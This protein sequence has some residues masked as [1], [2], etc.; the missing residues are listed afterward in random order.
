MTASFV[1]V[2]AFS[3]YQRKAQTLQKN[4]SQKM[5]QRNNPIVNFIGSAIAGLISIL[6]I[7]VILGIGFRVFLFIINL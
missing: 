6:V 3:Q 5:N 2:L 7:A 1:C 4:P